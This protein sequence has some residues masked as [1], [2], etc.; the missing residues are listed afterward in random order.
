MFF[1]LNLFKQCSLSQSIINI[2]YKKYLS[3]FPSFFNNWF[4]VSFSFILSHS[5]NRTN[6]DW[7]RLKPEGLSFPWSK[8][9]CNADHK[10]NHKRSYSLYLQVGL[11]GA[12]TSTF[13]TLRSTPRSQWILS[14]NSFERKGNKGNHTVLFE[15]YEAVIQQN[16]WGVYWRILARRIPKGILLPL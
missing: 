9:T 16:Y 4:N 15:E 13:V 10:I 3:F 1:C 11:N 2:W 7:F 8:M 12:V 5:K 14:L 6:I